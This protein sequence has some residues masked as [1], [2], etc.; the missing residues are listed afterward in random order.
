MAGQ[1]A[2]PVG[3]QAAEWG[4]AHGSETCPPS[5]GGGRGEAQGVTFR[6]TPAPGGPWASG[7]APLYTVC[8]LSPKY[9]RCSRKML[10]PSVQDGTHIR[11]EDLKKR[12]AKM[13]TD[14]PGRHSATWATHILR[15]PKRCSAL[16]GSGL[17][18]GQ[19]G[20]DAD[21][22]EW[23]HPIS[24]KDAVNVCEV[25]IV[26]LLSQTATNAC[27]LGGISACMFKPYTPVIRFLN[28]ETSRALRWSAAGG[29]KVGEVIHHFGESFDND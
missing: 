18:A 29:Q 23:H 16:R 2:G 25:D 10:N 14:A 6:S 4:W 11:Q 24:I 27:V 19:G 21:Q 3:G 20:G 15:R 13:L 22:H 28:G 5:H 9:E 17:G 7:V 26:R 8:A 1:C 12:A